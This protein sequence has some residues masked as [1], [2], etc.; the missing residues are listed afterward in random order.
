MA[1]WT[2]NADGKTARLEG[3]VYTIADLAD[4]LKVSERHVHRMR[5][6]GQLP[7]EIRFGTKAVRFVKSIIDCWLSDRGCA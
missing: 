6:N 4:L 7:G 1:T 2:A 5:A 3:A